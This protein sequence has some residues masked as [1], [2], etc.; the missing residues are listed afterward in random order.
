MKINS[1][2]F[3]NFG[4]IKNNKYKSSKKKEKKSKYQQVK[5]LTK[6]Y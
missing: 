5:V 1:K 4:K 6:I 3:N 2:I